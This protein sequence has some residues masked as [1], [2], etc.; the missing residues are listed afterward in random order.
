MYTVKQLNAM[1]YV[2]NIG[3]FFTIENIADQKLVFVNIARNNKIFPCQ[4][5]R[6]LLVINDKYIT[7][8]SQLSIEKI[9]KRKIEIQVY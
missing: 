8:C 2:S 4:R 5:M 3:D 7:M 6:L 9:V 1:Q